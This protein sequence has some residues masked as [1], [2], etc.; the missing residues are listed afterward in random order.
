M[1]LDIKICNKC[2]KVYMGHLVYKC[3]SCGKYYCLYCCNSDEDMIL[4]NNIL[5]CCHPIQLTYINYID[6]Y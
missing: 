5:I 6:A 3:L 1:T 4:L 2:K